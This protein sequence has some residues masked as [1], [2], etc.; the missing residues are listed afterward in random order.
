MDP[1]PFSFPAPTALATPAAAGRPAAKGDDVVSRLQQSELFRDYQDAFQTATGLPLTLRPAGSFQPPLYGCRLTNAFC[2]LMTGTSRTCAACLQVQQEAE[3]GALT[4]AKTVQ[5]FSGMSESVVPIR[6]GEQVIAY[7]QTGQVLLRAPSER[8][9][10]AALAQLARWGAEVDVKAFRDAYFATRVLP[11]TRY[12]AALRL[13]G[14]FAHH[15]SLLT[16]ELVLRSAAAEP[17]AA[18]RARAFIAAHLG[19]PLAL[20]QV[21][22]AAN[23]SPFY[24][25]KVFKQATGLT[26]THYV[27]RARIERTKQ[28]LLNPHMRISEAA[29]E[30]GFQ[31]LSQF[32]RVFRRIAGESPTRYRAHLHGAGARHP[33]P[34]A[35]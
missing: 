12:L 4:G 26:F 16:N 19:E 17:P 28:L 32:N 1:V 35:A 10:Q 34:F 29:Y 15:L 22:R 3:A 11:K 31:S 23:M 18:A 30:A 8:A 24:F 21:A 25:C 33:M 13:L 5:C 7:L 27:A 20:E 6:V 9:F 14:S 2:A